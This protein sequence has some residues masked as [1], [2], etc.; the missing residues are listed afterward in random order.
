MNRRGFRHEF[1]TRFA[2]P[3]FYLTDPLRSI[4][5]FILMIKQ[6]ASRCVTVG[7]V[8]VCDERRAT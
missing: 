3:L 7:S 8:P 4:N 6:V 2:Y 1:E 5:E